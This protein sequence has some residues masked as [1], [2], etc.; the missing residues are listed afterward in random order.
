MDSL[1]PGIRAGLS[2][3]AGNPSV[4]QGLHHHQDR[5]LLPLKMCGIDSS[6]DFKLNRYE[7]T[8]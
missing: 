2:D 7:A 1:Y 4:A 3:H 5:R 6:D 8:I